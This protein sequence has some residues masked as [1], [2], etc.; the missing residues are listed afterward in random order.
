MQGL[1][2]K[3]GFPTVCCMVIGTVIGS[4]VFYKAQDILIM[5]NGNMPLGILAWAV[6]GFVMLSCAV[7]FAIMATM[8]E[9]VGGV[10]DYAE[11]CCGSGYAYYLSW[12]LSTIHYPSL[13]SV[14]AWVSARFIGDLFGWD[15]NGSH[16]MMLAGVLLIFSYG[17]NA[18]APKFAGKLQVSTTIIK[19][20][21]LVLMAI[22][23]TIYGLSNGFIFDQFGDSADSPDKTSIFGAIVATAFA[24]EGWIIATSINA[25]LKDAKS[26]LPKALFFGGGLI[27]AL[28]ILYYIGVTGAATVEVLMEKGA[29][30]AFVAMFGQGFG[31]ILNVFV[32]ISCLGTLN[33]LMLATIRGYFVTATRL[34][35][36]AMKSMLDINPY[37]NISNN[38][39]ILGLITVACWLFY[40]YGANL[41]GGWFGIFNFDSSELPI[42]TIYAFYIPIFLCFMIKEKEMSKAKRFL[43][44]TLSILSSVF[45][46]FATVYAHGIKPY[47]E[48]QVN[49]EFSFP[50][51]F[52]L[53]VFSAI[54]LIG[55]VVKRISDK[56]KQCNFNS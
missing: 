36:N 29:T 26:N 10:V 35:G 52:Y 50:V 27:V 6:G 3:Y 54:M 34:N 17:T 12:F 30:A 21:P 13:T 11:A 8:Y 25:E 9:K 23:G 33:G 38:S 1:I 28:Y 32:A 31:V 42:I 24:Y 43:L 19:L 20:I 46:I 16:V 15:M 4:G 56:K 7:T 39:G 18:L 55:F 14:L 45:I 37:T 49:N 44:P 47:F 40:F 2:K 22:V 53:I 41:G 48:A 51:L 5:L